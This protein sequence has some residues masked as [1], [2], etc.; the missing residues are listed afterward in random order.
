MSEEIDKL[1][2]EFI[3]F[4]WQYRG[5]SF[6]RDA[7]LTLL[8]ALREPSDELLHAMTLQV[9]TWDDEASRRKWRAGIDHLLGA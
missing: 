7:V 9:P 5:T 3:T 6:G 8:R 1:A 4:Y 2:K